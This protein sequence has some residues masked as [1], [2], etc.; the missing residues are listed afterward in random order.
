[1]AKA[2]AVALE[3]AKGPPP[4]G[5]P[6]ALHTC[7][8]GPCCNE[9]HLFW[10]DHQDNVD[11][12]MAK[13]RG[14]WLSGADNPMFGARGQAHPN[15]TKN[16]V[17]RWRVEMNDAMFDA[18]ALKRLMYWIHTRE[19]V[20]KKKEAGKPP[21]WTT[22]EIIANYRF[23]SVRRND[24]KVTRW[25]HTNWL[26]PHSGDPDLWF[27]MVVARLVNWPDTLERLTKAVF[28][29]SGKVRWGLNGGVFVSEMHLRKAQ[30]DKVFS[31]AYI[32]STNGKA[33]DK[34]EYLEQYVL[35]PLW[36]ARA[37][38]RPRA[39][40]SLH[41]FHS[42]LVAY[43]GLG[44]FMAAQVVADIKY[45]PRSPLR[46]APDWQ[47]WAAPGPGSKRGLN[48]VMGA[49]HD[50]P[51]TDREWTFHFAD[52][53]QLVNMRL[54]PRM[55]GP[56]TGQDLQNCLCEFDKYER[57][58]LGQGKPRSGYTAVQQ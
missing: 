44:S 12:M 39:G 46:T 15:S 25:I 3:Y 45:D 22:D 53:L 55:G 17:K 56:L 29:G 27:A 34:A 1:M 20:R 18:D 14:K 51:F 58:R 50:R 49:D 7:D 57:V 19:E 21:P 48:R 30:G 37:V 47:Y 6:L 10:G 13:G 38:I 33:M 41:H 26:D 36:A 2:H 28:N 23:C 32:V 35:T 4:E 40:D 24:D 54:S 8:N 43:D 42:R 31:G 11:D 5:K 16:R 52:L 9:R